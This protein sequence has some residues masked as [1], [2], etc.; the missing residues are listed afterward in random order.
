MLAELPDM[1]TGQLILFFLLLLLPVLPN[2]WS[3][4]HAFHREFSSPQEKMGWI[5]AAVFIPVFGGLAYIF[6]G[7]KRGK[8]SL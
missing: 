1:S 6:F 4:Q 5:A 3:I 2:L 7:R 8:K